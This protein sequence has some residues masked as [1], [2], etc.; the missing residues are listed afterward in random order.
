[1]GAEVISQCG[2]CEQY[3]L[4]FPPK[5]DRYDW[6]YFREAKVGWCK[7]V[8][9]ATVRAPTSGRG[10]GKYEPAADMAKRIKWME[11]K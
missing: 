4:K 2:T 11:G 3:T 6:N 5:H 8:G 7:L 1:M 10:C 9:V